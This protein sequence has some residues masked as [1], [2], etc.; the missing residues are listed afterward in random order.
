MDELG[1]KKKKA[2]VSLHCCG[3]LDKR[4]RGFVFPQG[5]Q[6][7]IRSPLNLAAETYPA[8]FCFSK[9]PT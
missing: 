6:G 3:L 7:R 2:Q 8:E 5:E 1:A 4:V 9:P